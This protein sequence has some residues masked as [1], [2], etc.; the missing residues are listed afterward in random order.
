[1]YIPKEQEQFEIGL[2]DET[3]GRYHG[4]IGMYWQPFRDLS[5]KPKDSHGFS[6]GDG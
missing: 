6:S 3:E 4:V 1:L 5:S 2:G